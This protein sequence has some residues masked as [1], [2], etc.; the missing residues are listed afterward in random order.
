MDPEYVEGKLTHAAMQRLV[1][2]GQG[3]LYNGQTLTR[4]EHLPSEAT[5]AAGNPAREQAALTALDQ[6][7][8]GL[9]AQRQ[10]LA[11]APDATPSKGGKGGKP[12]EPPA[13][14]PAP[15]EPPAGGA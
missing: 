13:E 11:P 9:L 6:Q 2:A 10:A 12:P 4:P 3:V 15:T 7:I 1:A 5:L 8:A 14:P